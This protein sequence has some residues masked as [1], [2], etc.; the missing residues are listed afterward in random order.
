MWLSVPPS[1]YAEQIDVI[2]DGKRLGDG[3]T[4]YTITGN[5]APKQDFFGYEWMEPQAVG[6]VAYHTGA[7]EENGGWFT[8]LR[9][10]YRDNDGNW[11]PVEG[12]L[13]SPPLA[14]G[15]LPFNKPHF[16]E[17]LLAFRP[18]STTAIRIIGDAGG[19]RHWHSKRTCF[20]SITELS[21]YGSLPRYEFLN[22]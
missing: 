2:R 10:D 16:V 7:V 6:L 21:V 18:V 17:Y 22:R 9:V 5:S 12:L 19:T 13:T 3:S 20:T 11:K 1:L 4:F 15:H 8:S 14:P